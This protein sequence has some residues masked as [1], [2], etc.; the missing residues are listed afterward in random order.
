MF[1]RVSRLF[2]LYIY[3]GV[4]RFI[5]SE[6]WYIQNFV[7]LVY[8]DIETVFLGVIFSRRGKRKQLYCKNTFFNVSAT[9]SQFIIFFTYWII[10]ISRFHF[11]SFTYVH[12]HCKYSCTSSCTFS[13]CSWKVMFKFMFM[14]VYI[15]FVHACSW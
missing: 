3:I 15:S 10:V 12:V 6:C 5:C 7:C 13:F 14:F 8:G 1:I 11:S 4:Y 2:F 9:S